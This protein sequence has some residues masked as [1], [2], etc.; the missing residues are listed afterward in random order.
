MS[1][2]EEPAAARG[3]L[4]GTVPIDGTTLDY[5]CFGAGEETL[6]MLPGASE[7]LQRVRAATAALSLLYREAGRRY[8]VYL[9]GRRLALPEGF[10]TRDMAEDTARAM[11]AL[12]VSRAH[13]LGVSLGGMLAQ[14]LAIDH[15][16]RVDRLILAVTLCRPNPTE[17]AV[18]RGWIDMAERGD[19]RALMLDTLER[20][21]TE[22]YQRRF[23]PLY[24]FLSNS[25][26]RKFDR[27]LVQARAALAHDTAAEAARIAAPTLVIGGGRDAVVTGA[28]SEE[29]AARIPG[30]RLVL[31][32]ELSHGLYD[33][34]PDFLTRVLEFCGA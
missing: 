20:S 8:R 15:P 30:S 32:P 3:V 21:Y 22:A 24:A 19:Y 11:A 7:G 17:E 25:S 2:A 4:G 31:Y 29:L 34:A 27:F 12:G 16:E 18:L 26:R 33:E 23:K 1:T 9:F 10:T 13:V 6:V 5:A 28:A 14:H